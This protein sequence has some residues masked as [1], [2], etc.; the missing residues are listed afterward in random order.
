MTHLKNLKRRCDHKDSTGAPDQI[1]SGIPNP[2]RKPQS[3][4]TNPANPTTLCFLDKNLSL[5]L[6]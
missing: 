1:N 6:K 3:L 2:N 5:K 4:N